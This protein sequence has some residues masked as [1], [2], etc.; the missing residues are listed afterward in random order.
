MQSE[1]DLLHTDIIPTLNS[2]AEKYQDYLHFID[3]RW[4]VNTNS[5]NSDES[6]N[7]VLSICLD[8][9]DKSQPYM[10]IFIGDRYGWIPERKYIENIA[11]S[12]SFVLDETERSVTAL[13]IEY[14]LLAHVEQSDRC[15]ICIRNPLDLS[16][17]DEESRSDYVCE[18]DFHRQL[19][20]HL[21]TELQE[22]FADQIIYYDAGWDT[23]SKKLTGLEFLGER[24]LNKFFDMFRP[25]W[26]EI[27]D[28]AIP[29]KVH[30]S[31][32]HKVKSQTEISAGNDAFIDLIADRYFAQEMSLLFLKGTPGSGKTTLL[33]QTGSMLLGKKYRIAPFFCAY[34]ENSSSLHDLLTYMIWILE[35]ELNFDEHYDTNISSVQL[36]QKYLSQL[37]AAYE[38]S[39]QK[40]LI[41]LIDDVH[42][43]ANDGF[44]LLFFLPDQHCAKL[45][46]LLTNPEDFKLSPLLDYQSRSDELYV[47]GLAYPV[48]ARLMI[49]NLLERYHKELD[50]DVVDTIIDRG[51]CYNPLYINLLIN[52]LLMMDS[53]DLRSANNAAEL[54]EQMIRIIEEFPSDTGEAACA[55]LQAAGAKIA[56]VIADRVYML[57]AIAPDGLREHD[58]E[59]IFATNNWSWST[60]DFTRLMRYIRSFVNHKNSGMISFS[61]EVVAKSI[62]DVR[63]E[64]KK[65]YYMYLLDYVKELDVNDQLRQ[66]SGLELAFILRDVEYIVTELTEQKSIIRASGQLAKGLIHFLRAGNTEILLQAIKNIE[67]AN[68]FRLLSSFLCESFY[69][70]LDKTEHDQ[71]IGLLIFSLLAE[72]AEENFSDLNEGKNWLGNTTFAGIYTR[73]ATLLEFCEDKRSIHMMIKAA[74]YAAEELNEQP[75]LQALNNYLVSQY[76]IAGKLYSQ[77]DYTQVITVLQTALR[78]IDPIVSKNKLD[79]EA[80]QENSHSIMSIEGSSDI[81]LSSAALRLGRQDLAW[82]YAVSGYE[83]LLMVYRQIGD[84]ESLE[85]LAKALINYS[86]V[87]REYSKPIDTI[88]KLYR[89]IVECYRE[90]YRRTSRINYMHMVLVYMSSLIELKSNGE[91]D[92]SL[93]IETVSLS[94]K[95]FEQINDLSDLKRA[96]YISFRLGIFYYQNKRWQEAYD[97]MI[98]SVKQTEIYLRS[99]SKLDA[100]TISQIAEFNR[101]LSVLLNEFG[102]MEPSIHFAGRA[103]ELYG[104]VWQQVK[105]TDA[106]ISLDYALAIGCLAEDYAKVNDIETAKKLFLQQLSVFEIMMSLYP[107]VD[108]RERLTNCLKNL[109]AIHMKNGEEEQA[110]VF[111]RRAEAL[112]E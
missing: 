102:K 6:A 89:E 19:L 111:R 15:I 5:L 85:I 93:A 82:L 7:K 53:S 108:C 29:E 72:S 90:L 81:L 54:T 97:R 40:D 9:I 86:D 96:Y 45:K 33:C 41:F 27:E 64:D 52:R 59:R 74:D 101:Q 84:N 2:Y 70:L 24:I 83:K 42:K 112:M 109:Y 28:I 87:A 73:Y 32:L 68:Q 95:L 69:P 48:Q 10:L 60:I 30:M 8:E 3:L 94:E 39:D 43:L 25:E 35:R 91:L 107:Q 23:E 49:Y 14:G 80:N 44:P 106:Q 16:L 26:E 50:I 71:S 77:A 31:A 65:L 100:D 36:L 46:F 67:T 76:K 57:L 34:N 13:E 103:V 12:K 11:D 92:E 63:H 58:L 66:I 4:G 98:A 47:Y 18:S 17:M 51:D 88:E 62:V 110:W 99:A 75:S 79:S 22:K 38:M 55:Y 37:A 104:M 56:P 105:D 21:K 20:E 78:K 61:N 1:R